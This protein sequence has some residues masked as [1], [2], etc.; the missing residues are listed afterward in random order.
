MEPQPSHIE[1]QLNKLIQ[2]IGY[3]VS[4]TETILDAVSSS[5]TTLDTI[6]K[7]YDDVSI[8]TKTLHDECEEYIEDEKSL[9]RVLN[10]LREPLAYFRDLSV[11]TD[12]IGL[13]SLYAKDSSTEKSKEME[14]DLYC[15]ELS[16]IINRIFE[17]LQFFHSHPSYKDSSYYITK[18]QVLLDRVYEILSNKFSSLLNTCSS[19]VIEKKEKNVATLLLS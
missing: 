13:N 19:E 3:A 7:Q 16:S 5:I 4:S 14:Y 11:I 6:T 12:K 1:Q 17:C 8:V 10:E 9:S 2:N 15:E 18:Y